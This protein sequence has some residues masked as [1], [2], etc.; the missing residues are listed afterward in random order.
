M[1]TRKII[2]LIESRELEDVAAWLK[3]FKNLKF[4]NRDGSYTY[5]KAISQ[6]HPKAIQISDYFHL[7]KNLC[8]YLK[9]HL[10]RKL[11]RIIEIEG[12]FYNGKITVDKSVIKSKDKYKSEWE[13]SQLV[14]KM[15]EDGNSYKAIEKIFNLQYRTIKKYLTVS[16]EELENRKSKISSEERVK[17]KQNLINKVREL[18]EKGMSKRAIANECNIVFKTVNSYLDENM[19]PKTKV[20]RTKNKD[21]FKFKFDIINLLNK[22]LKKQ[23]IYKILREE[24]GYK[25]ALRTFYYHV[26]IIIKESKNDSN[27]D[28]GGS[29]IKI[30][31]NKI[32]S[33]LYKSI[34]KISDFPVELYNR[35]IQKYP[36][37]NKILELNNEFKKLVQNKDLN[38][39]HF[40]LKNA[41]ELN[42]RELNSF[43]GGIK[44]DKE[45]VY[46]AI[47][48]RFT[49]ALAEGSVN[50]LKTL[51][52]TMYGKA[53]FETLRRKLLWYEKNK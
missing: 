32:I 47:T 8:D 42:I 44:R 24:K 13:L 21:F 4:V 39:F 36:L 51:K 11:P 19:S 15:Y 17:R 6:A 30:K 7:L 45:A 41:A 2:D 1:E 28:S 33:L 37:V 26:S 48:Y 46:N 20:S 40:W 25:Y 3:K 27:I 14:K 9:E 10:V 35:I 16:K 12:F 43:I 18:Y 31:L 53:S 50:K 5:A 29:T 34:D 49:N 52:R 38:K 23:E 22:K